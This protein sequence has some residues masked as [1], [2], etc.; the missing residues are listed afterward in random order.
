NKARSL[1]EEAIKIRKRV[2]S[3]DHPDVVTS[4]SDLAWVL[5]R[6]GHYNKAKFLYEKALAIG[7]NVLGKDHP[8]ISTIMKDYLWVKKKLEEEKINETKT[9]S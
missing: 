2:L 3:Q 5:A 1:L 8:R 9:V 7:N 4:M 6:Q